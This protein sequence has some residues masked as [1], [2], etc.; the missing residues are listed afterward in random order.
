MYKIEKTITVIITKRPK[1]K[2]R[3]LQNRRQYATF[4]IKYICMCNIDL[5]NYN[6]NNGL[7]CWMFG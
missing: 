3:M 2:Q 6:G 4:Y 5:T 7:D 1:K